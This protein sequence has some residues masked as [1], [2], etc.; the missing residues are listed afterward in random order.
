MT[1]GQITTPPFAG[2][3][4]S[5]AKC[6][7][8]GGRGEVAVG[9][10]RSEGESPLHSLH[11]FS[12]IWGVFQ[13][14][15]NGPPKQREPPNTTDKRL[16]PF[17]LDGTDCRLEGAHISLPQGRPSIL[18]PRFF[19]EERQQLSEPC[20]SDSYIPVPDRVADCGLPPPLSLICRLVVRA[21]VAEGLNVTLIVQLPL[22]AT[23][24][25]QLF[26]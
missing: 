16:E 23:V 4:R 15:G 18:E 8:E 6:G 19:P 14:W 7:R 12:A 25:T 20:Q 1:R 21:P 3:S 9:A 2:H 10:R 26:V 22:A 13:A 17:S 11:R 5:S 24:P